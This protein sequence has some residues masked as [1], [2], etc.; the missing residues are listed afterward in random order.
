MRV[1]YGEDS[2]DAIGRAFRSGLLGDGSEA[3]ALLDMGRK[4]SNAYWGAYETGR[5][6]CPLAGNIPSSGSIEHLDHERIKRRELWLNGCL[7]FVNSMGTEVR[8][9]FDQL[10]ID[11][12][13]DCGPAWLDRLCYSARREEDGQDNDR[14]SLRAALDA[15]EILAR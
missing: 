14:R 13:P 10:V 3:K 5:F 12:N 1:L 7:D 8:R 6:T 2:A 11:V 4:I 15:L 9:A